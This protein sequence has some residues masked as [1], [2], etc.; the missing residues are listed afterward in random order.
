MRK[1]VLKMPVFLISMA[2]LV[3]L[4]V[5]NIVLPKQEFS[6]LENR[7]LS[8]L[9]PLSVKMVTSGQ[10]MPRAETYLAD[11]FP[12]RA[13]WMSL[14]ALSDAAFLRNERNGILIGK[15]GWLFEST[16]NLAEKTAMDNAEAVQIIAKN[17]NVPVTLMLIPFS[18]VVYPEAL[19]T[20]YIPDDIE[21]LTE[22]IAKA[23]P[24]AQTLDM[25]GPLRTAKGGKPLYFHTDHH[26]TQAGADVAYQALAQ[27]FGFSAVEDGTP[28]KDLGA[29]YG[30][31]YARAPSPLIAPDDFALA[32]PEGITLFVE[33]EEKPALYDEAAI[34]S[35]RDKYAQLLYGNHG[36]ITLTSDAPGGTLV[37][38]KDS[39]ANM[40]LPLL[41]RHYSRIEAI[42]P[43][44]YQGNLMQYLTETEKERVLCVYGLTIWIKDRNLIRQTALSGE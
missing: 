6:A 21:G 32:F 25:A 33:G 1:V 38:I 29:E 4:A 31:Y 42:D 44:Y 41:S 40:L 10:W 24:D 37:V 15:A 14:V 7:P 34:L 2:L 35:A 27:A 17:T 22:R 30:S 8:I 12:F 5:L 19:P 36:H 16:A 39:Y 3:S 20:A 26:W 28:Q 9:P 43:R 11:H 13:Q 23:A 18:S